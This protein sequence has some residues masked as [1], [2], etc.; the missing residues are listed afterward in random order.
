[1][2]YNGTTYYYVTNLQGDV[3]HILNSSKQVVASYSYDP[4]GKVLTTTGSM[5]STL[6][7]DNPLRYRGYV[8]DSETGFY[9]LQS[10]YYDPTIGRFINED[11][12]VSTGYG[13]LGLNMFAYCNNN[14]AS[15]ADSSGYSLRPSTVA[16]NDSG[17]GVDHGDGYDT[18]E[19]AAVAF[20]NE[21][22]HITE[23]YGNE[24]GAII[25]CFYKNGTARYTY[26][27]VTYGNQIKV[28]IN[29]SA[30]LGDYVHNGAMIVGDIHTH[31]TSKEFSDPDI[32]AYRDM[33]DHFPNHKI[34]LAGYDWRVYWYNMS[35]N[36][37]EDIGGFVP[38]WGLVLA[39]S[40]A[41][42]S[43]ITRYH[44]VH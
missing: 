42:T 20:A 24:V 29:I 31:A 4:Y 40:A 5:A 11:A 32:D 27:M 35:Q 9:Y 6:G 38:K 15:F 39:G 26:D 1:M 33:R 28:K 22:Y 2:T 23:N 36:I 25:V 8:Y 37:G 16:I 17:R 34:Y 14:P 13:I 7:A 30:Y 10:R 21:Y 3:L 43:V 44:S 12:L 19:D 41:S 18:P